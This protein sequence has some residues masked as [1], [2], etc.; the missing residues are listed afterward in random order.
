MPNKYRVVQ[1]TTGNVGK[2]SVQSIVANPQ[3]DLIGCYAW[4]PD[5]AGR[6]AGELAGIDPVGVAATNDVQALLALKPDCVVYNPMWIDVDE[7]VRIL[8]AGVNVV[9]TASFITG[10][11][12]GDGRD[13][14]LAACQE[15]GSTMFGSGV[16][17]GF[18][19]LLAIV[20]AMV[21][22]RVDKVTVN[23]AADTT[24]Y[25][26]PDT[27]RPVGF[28]QPIDH[29]ELAQMAEKGTAIFG[30]AVRLVADALGVDLDEI[31]C[32]PEFAETTAD[33]EM[34]SWT[35]PAGCVA[36][37]Y[38]SWQGIVAGRTVIDLN[39]RW[40]KGQTLEPDWKIDQDGWVIQ[41][42]G[43]PT[44]TTKVGFLPPPYFQA[45]T[46]AEFMALGHI[47][48]AMP[49]I[50]AIPAVVAAAPGIVTYTDLPLTLPRGNVPTG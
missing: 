34:A 39:V 26:S 40:R 47:M 42:D 29:P 24:F 19:E 35:I 9:T 10:H 31:R 20:S 14:I 8:S 41:V 16:S 38:I 15:G 25:D 18:A 45:T 3:F 12:L 49:A 5:K 46:L 33:L 32:V 4:S 28:G 30:E 13:R 43:Q 44:V 21:C 23:E 11:N 1:W 36:G 50:N 2:S 6:D 48:T 27:E 22:N 17:P 37:V 7:L